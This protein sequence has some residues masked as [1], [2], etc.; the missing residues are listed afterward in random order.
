AVELTRV[1]R[2]VALARPG[3]RGGDRLLQAD[4][5]E[6]VGAEPL[7]LRGEVRRIEAEPPRDPVDRVQLPAAAGAGGAFDERDAVVAPDASAQRAVVAPVQLDAVHGQDGDAG[8]LRAAARAP[9]AAEA[10]RGADLPD[11]GVVVLDLLVRADPERLLALRR[12]VIGDG[13]PGV[14]AAAGVVALAVARLVLARDREPHR[15][16]RG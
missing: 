9:V 10:E 6:R 5:L 8:R 4:E 12:R 7:P 1:A 11:D 16:Q 13:Q 14:E 3:E 2:V 15:V